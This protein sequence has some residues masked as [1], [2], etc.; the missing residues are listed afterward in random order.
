MGM[1]STGNPSY[2]S[3]RSK[4]ISVTR[5]INRE[6]LIQMRDIE[7]S[8][9]DNGKERKMWSSYRSL[10]RYGGLLVF[11][12][13]FSLLIHF[14]RIFLFLQ[15]DEKVAIPYQYLTNQS[16][17]SHAPEE[18]HNVIFKSSMEEG[19]RENLPQQILQAKLGFPRQG[20]PTF[21][22]DK[23]KKFFYVNPRPS[24][25]DKTSFQGCQYKACKMT[26]ILEEAD[27]L[28][29]NAARMK[30]VKKLPA[31]RD[32]QI[33]VMYSR[34]PTN[35][36]SMDALGLHDL[37]NKVNFS[38]MIYSD[39]T[40]PVLYGVLEERPL[41]Q[42]NYTKIFQQKDFEVAWFVSQCDRPSRRMEYVKRM[43]STVNVHIYGKCGNLT[44]GQKGYRMGGKK[45][46]CL[47]LLS[48]RYK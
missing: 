15:A 39:S 33:W 22:K 42:K 8:N 40:W 18:V 17:Q 41:P 30:K 2:C 1:P 45:L 28:L 3:V 48:S 20:S 34:E 12:L 14:L 13:C 16:Y 21:M 43:M 9:P 32:R 47:D 38:R 4:R 10:T 23:V 26:S 19:A 6:P 5:W 7:L 11:C 44:C 25:R 36:R 46:D 35:L 37:V 24:V 29:F 27:V 31:K